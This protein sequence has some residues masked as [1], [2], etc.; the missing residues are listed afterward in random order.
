M[1]WKDFCDLDRAFD[2]VRRRDSY[3]HT[4]HLSDADLR[5]RLRPLVAAVSARC[6][7]HEIELHREI[8]TMNEQPID[9]RCIG[10]YWSFSAA[11]AYAYNEPYGPFPRTFHIVALAALADVDWPDTVY[12]NVLDVNLEEIR[13]LIGTVVDI[14]RVM[15][16]PGG[17]EGPAFVR[18]P[19][20]WRP[21]T[22]HPGAAR[23]TTR[24][25]I[26]LRERNER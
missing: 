15:W 5:E 4:E 10:R 8:V 9:W 1:R 20:L 22:K 11:N 12:M 17:A 19:D 18:R 25:F 7:M 23:V 3:I 26:E 2:V 16:R 13:L 21:V 24:A 14:T 6:D